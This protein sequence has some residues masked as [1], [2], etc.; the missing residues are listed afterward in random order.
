MHTPTIIFLIS[1][2]RSVVCMIVYG[3]QEI[4]S[5]NDIGCVGN[6][7]VQLGTYQYPSGTDIPNCEH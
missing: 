4:Q 7:A 6:E 1:S 5:G 3:S 2:E